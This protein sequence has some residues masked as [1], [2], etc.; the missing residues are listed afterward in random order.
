VNNINVLFASSEVFPFAKTGGLG[1]VAGSLPKAISK[2]GTDIRVVMPKYGMIPHQYK[3]SM[4]FL[5]FIYVDLSWRHQYC[6]VLKLVYDEVTYYFLDNEDYFN[7][8]E[9]YGDFD[10]AEQFTFFSKAIIEM[11]PLIG[12]KP[13]II[14][15]NDW[16]T[17]GVSILWKANYSNT[18][19][20]KKMT[21]VF[22]MHK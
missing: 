12:F 22:R 13:D 6:G 15:C 3:D 10:E 2:L 20:N 21:R 1:D 14:H 8:S 9:L 19:F 4:E 18:P 5:G 11:L 7:R 16:Q 17:G